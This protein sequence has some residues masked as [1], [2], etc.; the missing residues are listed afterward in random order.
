M[1]PFVKAN[2][3]IVDLPNLRDADPSWEVTMS[4]EIPP[5]VRGGSG[6]KARGGLWGECL[7]EFLGTFVLLMIGLGSVAMTVAALPGSGRTQ[8]PTASLLGA[9]D[10]LVIAWGWAFA[11]AFGVY[12]AGGIS[13]AHLNPRSRW[14]SRSGVD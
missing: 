5:L 11:V 7:A 6:L 9:G 8:G 4:A 13:G 2:Y 10:W 3:Q 14:R 12:V 1:L